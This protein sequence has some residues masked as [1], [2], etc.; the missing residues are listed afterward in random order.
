MTHTNA[1][2]NYD[3]HQVEKDGVLCRRPLADPWGIVHVVS[4][5]WTPEFL[6]AFNG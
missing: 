3:K 5:Q 2:C 1:V 6:K 4:G